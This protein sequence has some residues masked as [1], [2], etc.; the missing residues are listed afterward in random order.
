M[1]SR[2]FLGDGCTGRR[3]N[4]G[5]TLGI[6]Q[7]TQS[8]MPQMEHGTQDSIKHKIYSLGGFPNWKTQ[9]HTSVFYKYT[10]EWKSKE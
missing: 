2:I 6:L 9:G 8:E 3:C 7:C 4:L 10:W 1:K 5:P